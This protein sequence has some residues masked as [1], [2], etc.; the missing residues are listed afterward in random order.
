MLGWYKMRGGITGRDR[1]QVQNTGVQDPFHRLSA[2]PKIRGTGSSPAG[3][4]GIRRMRD[5]ATSG[6]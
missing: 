2:L 1:T 3:L 4:H 6:S 5:D